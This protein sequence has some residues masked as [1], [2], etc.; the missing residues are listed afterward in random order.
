MRPASLLVFLCVACQWDA[1]TVPGARCD[2]THACDATGI[3]AECRCGRCVELSAADAGI[4]WA[5]DDPTYPLDFAHGGFA[6]GGQLSFITDS[7]LLTAYAARS[8]PM[9][10]SSVLATGELSGLLPGAGRH[11]LL[12]FQSPNRDPQVTVDVGPTTSIAQA[13]GVRVSPLFTDGGLDQASMQGLSGSSGRKITFGWRSGEFV[14]LQVDGLDAYCS[15]LEGSTTDTVSGMAL[16]I[17]DPNDAGVLRVR[18]GRVSD[19]ALRD[20]Q[21][22]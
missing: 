10:V 22:P 16:G 15:D 13:L 6:D 1:P 2:A 21:A 5:Q 19:D 8:F 11:N 18:L 14:Y 20:P 9:P 7:T 12:Q 3:S 4:L 17:I